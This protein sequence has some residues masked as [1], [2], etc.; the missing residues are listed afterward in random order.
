MTVSRIEVAAITHVG[1]VRA[2]NEDSL[3]IGRMV[4]NAS[5]S[6]V[7]TT[8]LTVESPVSMHVC[9]WLN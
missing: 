3:V 8:S 4:H 6:E 9:G 7:V 1:C 2:N 5:M